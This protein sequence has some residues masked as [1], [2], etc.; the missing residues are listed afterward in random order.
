MKIYSDTI[1]RSS[2]M[3]SALATVPGL[4]FA[5]VTGISRPRVRK[6]GW[7]IQLGREGSRRQFN[8]GSHGASGE[9]GAASWDD[10]GNFL[11]ALFELDPHIRA[12]YYDG[13]TNFH[14]RTRFRYGE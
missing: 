6:H 5:R 2:E 4:H 3:T 10:Y 14:Q 8:S 9:T 7:D 11:A 13:R 1:T 12:G